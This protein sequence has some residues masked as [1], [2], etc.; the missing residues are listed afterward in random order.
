M[1]ETEIKFY[2]AA[3]YSSHYHTGLLSMYDVSSEAEECNFKFYLILT[4]I[5]S[6]PQLMGTTLHNPALATIFL[7]AVTKGPE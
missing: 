7:T 3:S 5:H 2:A 6:H 4:N 1:M